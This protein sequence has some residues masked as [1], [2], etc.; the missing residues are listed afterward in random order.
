MSELIMLRPSPRRAKLMH[1]FR[2]RLP[3]RRKPC[4]RDD[5]ELSGHPWHGQPL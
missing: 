3:S 1:W 4:A 2:C 5:M